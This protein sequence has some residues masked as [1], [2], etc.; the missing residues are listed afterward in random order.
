MEHSQNTTLKAAYIMLFM[1]SIGWAIS[2]ILIKVYI[3]TIP[4]FHLLFG[5]FALGSVMFGVFKFRVLKFDK[6]IALHGSFLGFFLF[7]AYYFSV[8]ALVYTSASKAGFLVALSVLW[9]PLAQLVIKRR[10]P[11]RWVAL[12]V[13]LSLIGLYWIS[14]LD[15]IGFNVGDALALGCSIAYTVYIMFIDAYTKEMNEDQMTFV[16]LSSVAVF[17]FIAAVLFEGFDFAIIIRGWIPVV[18]I[19]IVGTTLSTYFQTKAQQVASPEAVGIIL[20]GE[21]LFTLLLAVTL[22]SE[23][24]TALGLIGGALLLFSLLIAVVKKI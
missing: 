22:L 3:D 14:G 6:K 23:S 24:V 20:L 13:G 7:L 1:T 2:T 17:S 18:A 12:S 16:I 4:P 10:L 5:R 8:V 9:V 21:P 11:N 15:G 19:S